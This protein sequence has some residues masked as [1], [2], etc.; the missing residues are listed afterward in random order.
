M[1]IV[2]IRVSVTTIRPQ[3][4]TIAYA[5]HR[6]ITVADLPGLIEGAHINVGMGHRFLKHVERTR[7]LLMVVDAEGFRLS[8][9]HAQRTCVQ[10]VFALNKELEMYDAELLKKPCVLLVNKVDRLDEAANGAQSLRD[11]VQRLWRLDEQVGD[12]PPE[13][14]SERLL[15]FE[16]IVAISAQERRNID[17]VTRA[18][19]GVLDEAAERELEATSA[20]EKEPARAGDRHQASSRRVSTNNR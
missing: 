15:R 3:I 20:A 2:C 6:Q 16:R 18:I 12:C 13:L 17:E 5:D 10:N 1:Q 7:M 14:R 19:R 8:P 9:A 4:G 11:L